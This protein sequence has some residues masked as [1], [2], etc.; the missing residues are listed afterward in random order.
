[1]LA[2]SRAQ[3]IVL[4]PSP[5]L[6]P[7]HLIFSRWIAGGFCTN[8]ESGNFLRWARLYKFAIALLFIKNRMKTPQMR[9]RGIKVASGFH[10]SCY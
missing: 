1:L 7:S 8:A 9:V 6:T 5:T 3:S 10:Q 4:F 2:R